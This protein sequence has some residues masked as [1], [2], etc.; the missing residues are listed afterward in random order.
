MN[1]MINREALFHDGSMEQV[2]PFE[3]DPGDDVRLFFRTARDDVDE[4]L[5]CMK[6]EVKSMCLQRFDELFSYYDVYLHCTDAPLSY[7]FKIRKGQDVCYYNRS[8]VTMAPSPA[9]NFVIRPGFST[10]DW[11]KGAIMY[12]IFTDRFCN[13]DKEN[14]VLDHEYSYIGQHVHQVKDWDAYPDAMDVRNFYG[15]DLQGV[16]DKLDYLEKLGVEVIYFNPLFVS[17]S[18]HKYDIQDYDFIDPHFGQIIND[19]GD[20]LSEGDEDNTHATRFRTR[21]TDSMNLHASND[22]FISVVDEIH[23]RGMRVILDGVFN[24]CGSF[25]KWMDREGI[26]LDQEG[27]E[28]GAY[29][30]KESPY[31]DYFQFYED[32]WPKNGSYNGWWGNDTLPKLNYE[33]SEKLYQYIMRIA[34]KWVSPPYNVD[35]WRLDVAQDLGFSEEFNH[36]FWTDFRRN[37]KEANPDAIILA[38]HYGNPRA[39]LDG[40]QWDTVMNYDAFMEPVSWFFTGMEKHSDSFQPDL[41]GN[42]LVFD[43][44][45]RNNMANFDQTS[46]LCAMNELSNHDHS[47]FLTRTNHKVGR[48]D[49]LG[50]KAAEEGVDLAVFKEAVVMQM[51][52]PGAPTVYYGEEVGLC[53]WT[54]PDNRRTYP[55]GHEDLSLLEFYREIIGIHKT[56][57][58]LRIGGFMALDQGHNKM[59][60]ARMYK[61]EVVV[62]LFNNSEEERKEE[63]AMWRVGG[64]D[65]MRAFRILETNRELY[66]AGWIP[67]GITDGKIRVKIGPKRAQLYYLDISDQELERHQL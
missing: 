22:F 46:I 9:F 6:N 35:G 33:G 18:N 53:G 19:E 17:A 25:N 29:Q 65:G 30:K 50:P 67:Y 12:Q 40:H 66:H 24:H 27:Y 26:Y 55:W 31:K 59:V 7:Y 8:G 32:K 37:V 14:D 38:E 57:L 3:P 62:A 56:Y 15:G 5:I 28:P 42:N 45:M 39:W 51:T 4:I 10:P 63:I 47:R 11:A 49:S 48:I 58:P 34:R 41:I 44:T 36:K 16:L 60:Y 20:L 61:H 1:D 2:I 54:D 23:A 21:V 64:E 43:M 13:G 52:W